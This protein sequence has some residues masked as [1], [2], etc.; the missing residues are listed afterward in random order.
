MQTI[1]T[2][3][4]EKFFPHFER[5]VRIRLSLTVGKYKVT[6]NGKNH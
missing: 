6:Q 5:A 3:N 2:R 1:N 4:Y